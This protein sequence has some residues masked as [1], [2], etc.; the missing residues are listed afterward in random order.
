MRC[1]RCGGV[2]DSVTG[3]CLQCGFRLPVE[4]VPVN[5]S[6][7]ELARD[8]CV[9][10]EQETVLPELFREYE[11]KKTRLAQAIDNPQSEKASTVV[12]GDPVYGLDEYARLL[13][14][15]NPDDI[16]AASDDKADAEESDKDT[17]AQSNSAGA[18]QYADD[19]LHP[20]LQKIDHIIEKPADKLLSIIHEKYPQPTRVKKSPATERLTLL[21]AAFGAVVVLLALVVIILSSIAP[22]ISGEWLIAETATGDRLTVEFSNSGDVK[23]RAYIDGQENIYMTG[24]YKIRRS[25]GS[26]LLTITY[27][28]GTEKRLYYV[29]EHDTG[30]F[31]NVDS[32]KSDTYTRIG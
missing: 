12:K 21:A 28:D 30:T 27:D 5:R 17:E 13:G 7:E 20:I 32:N 31:T 29:V 9:P 4:H 11:D 18:A 2:M 6:I 8:Y 23:A 19:E 10:Q 22:D 1:K 15:E 3:E 16:T 25:N 26:N 24:S 14:V